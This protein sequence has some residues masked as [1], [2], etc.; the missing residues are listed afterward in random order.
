MLKLT[1]IRTFFKIQFIYYNFICWIFFLFSHKQVTHLIVQLNL[2]VSISCV[3]WPGL[4]IVCLYLTHWDLLCCRKEL[5]KTRD[6]V[7]SIWIFY[8]LLYW[9]RKHCMG[10]ELKRDAWLL[11]LHYPQQI[12]YEHFVKTTCLICSAC[13][14]NLIWCVI[15]K[16]N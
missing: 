16:K 14:I 15:F 11:D 1:L 7:K 13:S 2:V 8:L 12:S 4:F 3:R 10:L 6:T 9:Q 5:F